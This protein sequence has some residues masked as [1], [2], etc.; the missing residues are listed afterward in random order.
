MKK[1]ILCTALVAMP[2]SAHAAEN[3]ALCSFLPV[4]EHFVGAD[5]VPGVDVNGKVVVPADV[6]AQANS[7]LDVIKVPVDIDLVE[8]LQLGTVVPEGTEMI[9][10]FG[11]IEVYKDSKVLYN[12]E[13]I[14]DRAYA[15][16]GKEPF[17]IESAAA[18]DAP[19]DVAPDACAE[20]QALDTD[21]CASPEIRE[22]QKPSTPLPPT[23][24]DVVTEDEDIIW[25]D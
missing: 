14:S 11:M 10:N 5:Y 4:K 22:G 23:D 18:D 17:D 1:F 24:V 16:C 19:I 9:A 21:N 25:V 7:Y 15:Y 6:K 12:G 20:P 13:D 2:I 8:N 3:Q